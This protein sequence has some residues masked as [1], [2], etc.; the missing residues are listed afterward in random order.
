MEKSIYNRAPFRNE[1]PKNYTLIIVYSFSQTRIIG[2]SQ[3]LIE[4]FLFTAEQRKA[5]QTTLLEQ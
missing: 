1:V 2:T 3:L 5:I 4:K